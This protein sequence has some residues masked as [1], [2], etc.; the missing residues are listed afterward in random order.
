MGARKDKRFVQG[1]RVPESLRLGS[2]PFLTLNVTTV[3]GSTDHPL[4]HRAVL[5]RNKVSGLSDTCCF[6]LAPNPGLS[7]NVLPAARTAMTAPGRGAQWACFLFL[8]INT[9][10]Y[11]P[12]KQTAVG[13]RLFSFSVPI[14]HRQLSVLCCLDDAKAWN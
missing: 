6:Y 7:Q 3:Q 8:P 12:R 1:H 14:W 9:G 11:V 4:L 2:Q 10:N 5:R 13:F